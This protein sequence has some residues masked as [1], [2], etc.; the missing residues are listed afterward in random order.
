MPASDDT[1]YAVTWEYGPA[2]QQHIRDVNRAEDLPD[3]L[4]LDVGDG[5]VTATG[6]PETIRWLYDYL[7]YLKRAWRAEGEQWDA[8]IAEEMAESLYEQ[9]DGDLP[10]RQRSKQ[11]LT[12][13]GVRDV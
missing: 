5:Q 8:D 1:E 3:D 11:A 2:E 9:V 7:H 6:S 13:G 4:E 12:D 10:D